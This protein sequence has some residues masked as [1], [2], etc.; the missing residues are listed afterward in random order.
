MNYNLHLSLIRTTH[1]SHM[2][3]TLEHTL[4]S[5]WVSLQLQRCGWLEEAGRLHH[6]TSHRVHLAF[7]DTEEGPASAR[8]AVVPTAAIHKQCVFVMTQ[9][10]SIRTICLLP[11]LSYVYLPIFPVANLNPEPTKKVNSRSLRANSA[12]LT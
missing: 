9:W 1:T 8:K 6:G 2:D 10:N 5:H 4:V 11:F 3:N 7:K 12:K